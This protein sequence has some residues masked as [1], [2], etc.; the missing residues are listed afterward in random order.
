MKRLF[1]LLAVVILGLT[2][3][4]WKTIDGLTPVHPKA[5]LTYWNM[6]PPTVG[7]LRPTFRWEPV[8]EPD[9]RYDFIIYESHKIPAPS[10][11]TE[12]WAI[13][14]E[15]YYRQGFE[16]PEHELEV[17]L[18]PNSAYYWSVRVRRG[19]NVSDWSRFAYTR[20][21][22][23]YGGCDKADLPFFI[24]KTPDN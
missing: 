17:P 11:L 13:G 2:A 5:R 6:E 9:A 1:W 24:F 23:A 15:V 19:E 12:D 7:S 8:T 21:V 22:P 3:C 4:A 16:E 18:Q 14:K 20:C 10:L